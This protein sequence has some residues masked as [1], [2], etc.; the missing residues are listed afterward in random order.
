MILQHF[1]VH[2]AGPEFGCRFLIG[3]I[4]LQAHAAFR[5]I[6][7]LVRFDAR[8]HRAVVFGGGGG[9]YRVGMRMTVTRV[10]MPFVMT[11]WFVMARVIIRV[12]MSMAFVIHGNAQLMLIGI[13]TRQKDWEAFWAKLNS[14][15][16]ELRLR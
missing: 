3:W 6:A 15:S 14:I 1:R 13:R 4:V 8:T 10:M 5:A 9:L 12:L 16:P 2:W 11:L 7:W